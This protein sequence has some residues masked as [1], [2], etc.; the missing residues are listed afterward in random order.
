M[1]VV[2]DD[3]L[4][5][6]FELARGISRNIPMKIK[7]V[8]FI[9]KGKKILAIGWNKN[10]THPA[11]FRHPYNKFSTQIHAEL[12]AIIK[13]GRTDCSKYD[14][15]VIRIRP[16][17]KMGYSKPCKGCQHVIKQVGFNSVYYSTDFNSFIHQTEIFV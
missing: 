10:K 6:L 15:V 16:N 4:N 11:I 12:D 5:K 13:F 14:I 3:S 1:R 9:C 7:H 8:C 17:G 2:S